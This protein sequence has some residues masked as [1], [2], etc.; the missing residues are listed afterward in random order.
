MPRRSSPKIY[1]IVLYEKEYI[2]DDNG[3]RTDENRP[4]KKDPRGR[5]SKK[6]NKLFKVHYKEKKKY[7]NIKKITK[8]G[9]SPSDNSDSSLKESIN[10]NILNIDNDDNEI[11]NYFNN[12]D[13]DFDNDD[14]IDFDFDFDDKKEFF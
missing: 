7:L 1:K 14:D 5:R 10:K 3:N 6:K 9:Q 2:L 11:K 12:V 8:L 4:S 13:F